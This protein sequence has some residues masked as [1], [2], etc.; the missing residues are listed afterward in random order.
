MAPA[1]DDFFHRSTPTFPALSHAKTIFGYLYPSS[2]L[3]KFCVDL[4]NRGLYTGGR[5]QGLARNMSGLSSFVFFVYFLCGST[6]QRPPK[7]PGLSTF[8]KK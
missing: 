6:N 7:F 1:G 5:L 3:Q 8:A 2:E 4:R